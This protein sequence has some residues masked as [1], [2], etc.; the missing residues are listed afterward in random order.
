M[1]TKHPSQAKN[2]LALTPSLHAAGSGVDLYKRSIGSCKK[3]LILK[4]R[5]EFYSKYRV[6]TC[7]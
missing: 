1:Y 2:I 6:I 3:E 4:N 5:V 7:T